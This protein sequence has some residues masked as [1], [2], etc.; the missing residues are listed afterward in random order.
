MAKP[1]VRS[2]IAVVNEAVA[3]IH[4][5]CKLSE[6]FM[7]DLEIPDSPKLVFRRIIYTLFNWNRFLSFPLRGLLF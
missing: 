5:K 3:K 1:L 7:Q 4:F 6:G 2:D